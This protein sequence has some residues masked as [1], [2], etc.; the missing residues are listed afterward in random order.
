MSKKQLNLIKTSQHVKDLLQTVK[1][2]RN[3]SNKLENQAHEINRQE[4]PELTYKYF[5]FTQDWD[6]YVVGE[7]EQGTMRYLTPEEK[8]TLYP[9]KKVDEK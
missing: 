7:T 9:D 1:D 5:T 6:M 8:K 2:L 3:I 4:H